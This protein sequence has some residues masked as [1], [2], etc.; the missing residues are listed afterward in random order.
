M[1]DLSALAEEPVPALA[2]VVG[3][4]LSMAIAVYGVRDDSYWDEVGTFLAFILGAAMIV[5]AFL[6]GTEGTVNWLSLTILVIVALTLF[7]KPMREIPW[8]GVIGAVVGS[9]ASLAA[10]LV[11]PSHVFGI[12]EWIILLIVFFVVG[13]I[14]AVIFHFLEDLLTIATMV[15]QWKPT[16]VVVGLAAVAEGILLLLDRSILSFV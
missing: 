9:A 1:V 13:G 8:S 7:L 10:S 4:L 14:V 3:G 11:L 15:L 2:L 5:L 12:D 16:M 6:A